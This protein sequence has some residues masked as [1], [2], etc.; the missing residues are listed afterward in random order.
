MAAHRHW[1]L[2]ITGGAESGGSAQIA[3]AEIEL[4][5]APGGADLTGAGTASASDPT[6]SPPAADAFDDDPVSTFWA[7][8]GIAP[9]PQ[10]LA[11]DLGAGNAAEVVEYTITAMGEGGGQFAPQVFRL[12]WSDDGAAWTDAEPSRDLTGTW[13]DGQTRT[14]TVGGGEVGYD[15]HRHWRVFIADGADPYG[16]VTLAEIELRIEAGGTDITGFGTATAS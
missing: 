5:A 14:F 8:S 7:S 3:I 6:G 9:Y 16:W 2:Y 13:S 12:Q 10:W 15:G 1:R 11:Y 4:R